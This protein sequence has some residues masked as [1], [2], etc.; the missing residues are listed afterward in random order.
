MKDGK[1][2]VYEKDNVLGRFEV[3]DDSV[4]FPSDADKLN[5][6]RFPAGPI[7]PHTEK[8]LSRL[9]KGAYQGLRLERESTGEQVKKFGEGNSV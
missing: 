2:I 4:S 3:K 5:I 7:S 1:Y 6:D 9:L 8:M